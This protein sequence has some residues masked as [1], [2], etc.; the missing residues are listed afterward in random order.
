MTNDNPYGVSAFLAQGDAVGLLVLLILG[1]MSVA[2]WY[3]I[4]TKSVSNRRMSK[5]VQLFMAHF[6]GAPSID[7]IAAEMARQSPEEP[8]GRVAAQA[9]EARQHYRR[10]MSAGL[11]DA[12]GQGEFLTRSIRRAIIREAGALEFGLSVLASIGSTAP[13][14]GL[15]G[16]VWGIY[17]ALIGIGASGAATLDAVAGPVGEAL[18][19]TAAG[20]FVAIPAVLAHN[21]FARGNRTVLAELDGFA[22]DLHAFLTTGAKLDSG[23]FVDPT[24]RM[25]VRATVAKAA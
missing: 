12:G 4:A 21:A 7:T 15:F 19:M 2:T 20:L 6:W 5:R 3:L 8:F 10:S 22:H 14:V 1:A 24:K 11:V 17:H 16:T 23:G 9:M 18:I 13:F 25:D